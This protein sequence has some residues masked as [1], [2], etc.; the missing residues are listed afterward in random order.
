MIRIN[1]LKLSAWHEKGAVEKQAAR[2]LRVPPD[3]IEGC[4]IVRRS[5]DAR[6]KDAIRYIYTV[7]VR[8]SGGEKAERKAAAR[9]K[10]PNLTYMTPVSYRAPESGTED[11][12]GRIVVVGSGPAGLFCT[13]MLAKQGYRP[14]LLERG[15]PV[16][17]RVED[18]E[19][20]WRTGVLKPES[21]VQFGEGGAGTFSDGKL[22][23]AVKDENGRIRKVLETFAEHGAPEDILYLSKPHIGTDRLRG[24]VRAMRDS[25][26][27]LGGEVRFHACL[28][29]IR[30]EDGRIRG[31]V[32]NGTEERTIGLLVLAIGHSARDTFAMLW[33]RGLGM[34]PKAFAVG[35][36]IEHRQEKIGQA[37]YGD[38]W[39][40]LPAADY[41]VTHTA[42]DGRG[43]YSF[44]MCPGGCVVNASSEEGRLAVNGM[45]NY[46]RDG[47][48]ANSALIVTVSPEDYASYAREHGA[49]AQGPDSPLIGLEFQRRLEERAYRAGQGKVPVSLYGDFKRHTVSRAAGSVIPS[50]RGGWHFADLHS[51]LPPFVSEDIIEGI[52]AFDRKIPGFAAEDAVLSGVES[53][54]SSPVRIMR[55]EE[56]TAEIAGI[57]PCGEGAGYAGGIT[58][59]AVDGIRVFEA[60]CRRY[61]P[62]A[63]ADSGRGT[64][65]ERE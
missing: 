20:F 7:D 15:A 62:Y 22:N 14:L 48:N 43:V 4:F 9:L 53:R 13:Y 29:D 26:T 24:V 35:L 40:R 47:E 18:V 21:N 28:T 55:N 11:P 46:A 39:D 8:L 57:Y 16:E 56:Y 61:R 25:I 65:K 32:I 54:T 58:S 3:R 50:A 63:P 10:D 2:L 6:K 45:S 17:E 41:K 36:R 33:E 52:E 30:I 44:C 49:P 59:A 1:Q 42:K 23:T 27:A 37:Q 38:A 60:I 31:I 34:R 51:I 12:G 19:A 64:E 5:L